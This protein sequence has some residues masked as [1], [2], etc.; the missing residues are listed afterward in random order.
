MNGVVRISAANC[1]NQRGTGKCKAGINDHG[2]S[3][4]AGKFDYNIIA[5]NGRRHKQDVCLIHSCRHIDP[6]RFPVLPSIRSGEV[7]RL[8]QL[9]ISREDFANM[10]NHGFVSL[11]ICKAIKAGLQGFP[12]AKST[13]SF[14]VYLML[15][16][17]QK[18]ANLQLDVTHLFNHMIT[19]IMFCG[20]VS[21]EVYWESSRFRSTSALPLQVLLHTGCNLSNIYL[22]TYYNGEIIRFSVRH[23]KS[24]GNTNCT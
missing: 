5:A 3:K 8:Q 13:G 23:S 10:R 4:S 9:A 24:Q 12:A 20:V 11:S 14:I 18:H 7:Y 1:S 2:F 19:S 21:S 16:A 15:H 17:N 22:A 6:L